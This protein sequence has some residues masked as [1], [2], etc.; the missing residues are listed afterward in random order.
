MRKPLT[1]DWSFEFEIG[2]LFWRHQFNRAFAMANI[3]EAR[4]YFDSLITLTDE[5]YNLKST[6]S[7]QNEPEGQWHIPKSGDSKITALYLHGGGYA[8]SSEISANFAKTLASLLNVKLFMPDYRLTPEHPHP[9]QIE[10]ALT[11][12]KFLIKKGVDPCKLIVIGDSAGGHLALMLLLALQEAELQQPALVIGLSPW[13]DIG[14]RGDSFYG[15][16]IYD[17]VQGYMAVQFGKW[18][19]G[20][21]EYSNE[22]LSPIYYDFNGL[23]PIYLQGGGREIFADMIRDFAKVLHGQRHDVSLDIWPTMPHVFHMHGLTLPESR[24]AF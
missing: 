9:A 3:H 14:E 21:S 1:S 7:Q 18:L 19:R 8:F 13:T 2:V 15:N 22:E 23:A 6:P 10:D 4:A 24:Q 16:G 17:L 12:Y 5:T 20:N 11:A